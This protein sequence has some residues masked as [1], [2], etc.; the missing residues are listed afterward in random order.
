MDAASSNSASSRYTSAESLA[1]FSTTNRF[2]HMKVSDETYVVEEETT[3][4]P[5]LLLREKL[6]LVGDF[7]AVNVLGQI[8]KKMSLGFPQQEQPIR[9]LSEFLETTRAYWNWRNDKTFCEIAKTKRTFNAVLFE[10]RNFCSWFEDS[11][12]KETIETMFQMQQEAAV[13]DTS[14]EITFFSPLKQSC[15]ET[16]VSNFR[17]N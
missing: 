5:H 11:I 6:S 10:I 14:D 1:Q 4:N 9:F 16:S 2:R 3:T 7:A 13:H 12:C 8:N 17:K 15:S